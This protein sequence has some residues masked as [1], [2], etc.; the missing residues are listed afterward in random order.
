MCKP[1]EFS[2][3]SS[4]TAL[5][6][7]LRVVGLVW[8][9]LLVYLP[10]RQAGQQ[11]PVEEV[12][13]GAS[14][15]EVTF[16]VVNSRAQPVTGL[17]K[18]DFEVYHDGRPQEIAFFYPP[19][20]ERSSETAP[21]LLGLLID[22]SGSMNPHLM[23]VREAA[24]RFTEKLPSQTQIAVCS[25][26]DGLRVIQDFTSDRSL[27]PLAV[28]RAVPI[29]PSTYIYLSVAQ[30]IEF[31][32][33]QAEEIGP[34]GCRK[35][36]VIISD[37]FDT[38][39]VKKHQATIDLALRSNVKI[40]TV[41]PPVPAEAGPPL[42]PREFVELAR[43]TGGMDFDGMETAMGLEPALRK[44]ATILDH[45]YLIAYSLAEA[46]LDGKLHRIEVKVK[47]K[48]LKVKNARRGYKPLTQAEYRR[49][50]AVV[51]IQRR[52]VEKITGLLNQTL[53]SSEGEDQIVGSLSVEPITRLDQEHFSVP[54]A[55]KL[56]YESLQP[57]KE[58]ASYV[59]SFDYVMRV[60]SSSSPQGQ[61]FR[62]QFW[63]RVKEKEVQKARN[64]EVGF[65][66]KLKLTRGRYWLK[67]A[68]VEM[69]TG[70]GALLETR[71][72]IPQGETR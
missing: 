4:A 14:L 53:S 6:R 15:V 49:S 11:R 72:D 32:N 29:S 28:M 9:L 65:R 19:S 22:S 55:V 33:T 46:E 40:F 56:R 64:G 43:A 51:E 27:I 23:E 31:L 3:S 42:A 5:L 66:R 36:L 12:R 7:N 37:G 25:F 2:R 34:R 20:S 1:T 24:R 67:V 50:L 13:L 54:L 57:R 30:A 58:N 59:S 41:A 10:P 38:Q 17:A 61:E 52:A 48:G 18:G 16:T 63:V 21:L 35:V 70:R 62:D 39:V 60:Q 69:E 47:K 68:I 45:E 71:F 44:L 8:L 26:G